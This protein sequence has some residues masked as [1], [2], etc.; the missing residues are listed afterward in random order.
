MARQKKTIINGVS[1]EAADDAFAK[2]A[3]SDAQIQ[4]INAEIDLQCAKIREKHAAELASLGEERDKAFETLQAFAM[5]NQAELFTKK[6]SLEMAHGTIGFRTGTPKLKTLKKFTW[7]SALLL[8]K[9]FLPD[10]YIRQTEELAKDRLLADRDLK[11][12]RI[13]NP[14]DGSERVVAM[15]EAMAECGIQVVQDET[16]YVEPKKEDPAV[17]VVFG[18]ERN[19]SRSAV[20]LCLQAGLM[21]KTV[22]FAQG[23]ACACADHYAEGVPEK[24]VRRR[25]IRDIIRRSNL[26]KEIQ[27]MYKLAADE[28]ETITAARHFIGRST[29]DKAVLRSYNTTAAYYNCNDMLRSGFYEG[30]WQYERC[31]PY[32]IFVSQYYYPIKGFHYLLRAADL[33]KD[34]YP[35]LK[36]VASGYNPI[37]GSP[38]KNELK[39]SSYIRYIKSLIREFGLADHVEFTGVLTEE[40]MKEEYLKANVFVLPST[41]EN[42]PNSLAEA[43]TLGV[44]C[45]ASDVGG[46]SDFAEHRKEAFLYPSSSTHL[47]AYYLDA[48]FSDRELASQLGQ[49]ARKRAQ[50]DYDRAANT[51]ALEQAFQTIA[52][53]S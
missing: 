10:T 31:E 5:E 36:I 30:G 34:K 1:R 7:A 14:F 23:L 12:V 6:K 32:R 19:Y 46:V 50:I 40:R 11:E 49:N 45:I 28:K 4:K 29:L 48:V 22:L 51:A 20:R 35:N 37:M 9:K 33:L 21:D 39:D 2:Y 41:I 8:A 38:I 53:K 3:K 18:T 47:L 43:M 27:K 17:I 26:S 42:S 13:V 44:P 15:K 24:V 25:T 16:F 52:K